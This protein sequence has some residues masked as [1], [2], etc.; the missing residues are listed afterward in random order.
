M[1]AKLRKYYLLTY[2]ELPPYRVEALLLDTNSVIKIHDWTK[3]PSLERFNELEPIFELIRKAEVVEPFYGAFEAS[4][5]WDKDGTVNESNFS[6]VNMSIFKKRMRAVET[7][8]YA[9]KA[10]YETFKDPLRRKP[11]SLISEEKSITS[12]LK[13]NQEEFREITTLF[14]PEWIAFL[15][16]LEQV[17]DLSGEENIDELVEKFLNWKSTI[18]GYG[19]PWRSTVKYLGIMAFFGGTITDSF[20]DVDLKKKVTGRK[21]TSDDLLKKDLWVSNGLPKVARNLALDSFF[22]FERNKLQS[23]IMQHPDELRM[24]KVRELKTGIITGDRMMNALNCQFIEYRANKNN[25]ASYTIQVPLDSKIFDFEETK[26]IEILSQ[27]QDSNSRSPY[28][29][30]TRDE[31]VPL[32]I[33]LI[34]RHAKT[35]D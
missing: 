12:N 31:Q 23:G 29:M 8:R 26:R 3:E 34:N 20:W 35:I 25:L 2:P 7:L 19:I 22:F 10:E 13:G 30:P 21:Y 15:L 5:H 14:L 1:G 24:L 16:L 27:L 33:S 17:T 18:V 9:S 11:I 6:L 32:L 4:W 28:D